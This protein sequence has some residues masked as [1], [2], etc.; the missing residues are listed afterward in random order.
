ML[1]L[2]GVFAWIGITPFGAK[3]LMMS[4]LG[5]QYTEFFSYFNRLLHGEGSILYSFTV[6]MGDSFL[7]LAGYYLMSPFNFLFYF[8]KTDNIDMWVTLIL[9]LKISC[10]SGAMYQYIQRTYKQHS[11]IGLAFSFAYAL[12][13]FVGVYYTN[14]M[15]LD[16]VILL[17][18]VALGIQKLVDEKAGLFFLITLTLSIV[19]NYYLGYMTCLFSI[20]YF[21]YW[22]LRQ[23]DV[24]TVKG[25]FQKNKESTLSFVKYGIFSG[26]LSSF[27]LIPS[28]LG[29]M[30][31][32]K[33]NFSIQTFLPYPR[34]GL[35]FFMQLGFDNTD[36]STRLGHLPSFY[37]GGLTILLI[38]LH[39]SLDE[40]LR[41]KR[42]KLGLLLILF[43]SM[44]IQTFN[45]VWHMFQNAAGFPY[46]NGYML[47]FI[48]LTFA[49]EAVLK[50]RVYRLGEMRK[51]GIW[52]T[53]LLMVGYAVAFFEKEVIKSLPFEV[54]KMQVSVILLLASISAIGLYIFILAHQ[55]RRAMK[56]LLVSLFFVDIGF[57]FVHMMHSG[58]F[59]NSHQFTNVQK[60]NQ[61][62]ATEF[63]QRTLAKGQFSRVSNE[64]R[65]V[66]NAYNESILVNYPGVSSYSS[67]L[68]DKLRSTLSAIGLFSR[69]ERRI[70]D[71]GTTDFTNY[72]LNV[73][74]TFTKK[75]VVT[76]Q[77]NQW[78]ITQKF[79]QKP[80]IAYT[81]DREIKDLN[82][83]EED[84][85]ENVDRVAKTVM[86][87]DKFTLLESGSTTEKSKD[88]YKTTSKT[89][90]KVYIYLPKEKFEHLIVLVNGKRVKTRVNVK[91]DAFVYLGDVGG[92]SEL[93]IQVKRAT[94]PDEVKDGIFCIS[95]AK[96]AQVINKLSK[97]AISTSYDVKTNQFTL[98]T[99]KQKDKGKKII[100]TSIP[101][102][103]NWRAFA[104]GEKVETVPVLN[105]AFLGIENP[106]GVTRIVLRHDP[107]ATYFATGVSLLSLFALCIVETKA[108]L[109][110]RQK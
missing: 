65:Q 96:E 46:R 41:I 87:N 93:I 51:T 23:T 67:T 20:F 82:L 2:V 84:A 89:E 9:M 15:W 102:D 92:E 107:L 11:P 8:S 68:N 49:Y 37:V 55:K 54:D 105:G 59:G 50:G 100:F 94:H 36:F 18:L 73:G 30:Q 21:L 70:S 60:V 53:V 26:L 110:T 28:L 71:V 32:G 56:F 81:L 80:S 38:A 63:N 88:E 39:L 108:R 79:K 6:G 106:K 44:N 45:A 74:Y 101:Y 47:S 75:G 66:D 14:I 64:L 3:N 90:G 103:K 57:N 7:P 58:E 85:I 17:P 13:G 33:T 78:A 91:T 95:K 48:L 29:M 35:E 25:F 109:E 72:L 62:A 4:D 99:E 77:T 40:D 1:F 83:K 76:S 22:T 69:N 43:L 5:T 16:G 24:Q 12:S 19:T 104:N 97:K 27:I 86:G 52:M 42:L 61:E 34:F 31:T 10:I 98:K